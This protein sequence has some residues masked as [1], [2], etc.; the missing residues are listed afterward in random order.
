MKVDIINKRNIQ[1]ARLLYNQG[2]Y[3][4]AE[5]YLKDNLISA[6]TKYLLGKIYMKKGNMEEAKNWF[7]NAIDNDYKWVSPRLELA[8]IWTEEGKYEKA[9]EEYLV[10]M[11][12]QPKDAN[13]KLEAAKFY[14]LQGDNEKAK[15]LIAKA[16]RISQ[17]DDKVLMRS[18]EAYDK[19]HAYDE[20][21]EICDKLLDANIVKPNH[22]RAIECMART[23]F[24]LGK[25]D[26]VLKVFAGKTKETTNSIMFNLYKRRIYCELTKNEEQANMYQT[27]LSNLEEAYGE[28][29]ILKH[30]EKH[31][32]NNQEKEIHGVFTKS[33]PEILETVKTAPKTKQKGFECDIYCIRLDECGYQGG[34]KGDGH[35]L[36]YITL[37]TMPDTQKTITMFPSDEIKLEKLEPVRTVKEKEID[38][39]R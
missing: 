6:K 36:N 38:F 8:R 33:L 37:I 5:K 22:T 34:N 25:Y 14:A 28:E 20:M 9:E 17:N 16:R 29:G 26:K 12:R 18:L 1:L 10:C 23:Y 39:E 32:K 11:K 4:E 3:D 15:Q 31:F 30:I 27:I 7:F 2:K 21:H 24:T 13:L 35:T 19:I